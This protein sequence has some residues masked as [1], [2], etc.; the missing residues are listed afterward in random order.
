MVFIIWSVDPFTRM[1][2]IEFY[3][4]IREEG[5]CQCPLLSGIIGDAWAGNVNIKRVLIK[6]QIS[7]NLSYSHGMAGDP[8]FLIKKLER[9]Y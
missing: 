3:S 5:Y 4:K 9:N 7:C 6:V 8:S 1:Y 2:Q